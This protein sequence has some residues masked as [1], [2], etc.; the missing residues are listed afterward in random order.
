VDVVN[1]DS[2]KEANL[3]TQL[4]SEFGLMNLNFVYCMQ[5]YGVRPGDLLKHFTKLS[6]AEEPRL[7]LVKE[8]FEWCVGNEDPESF[9]L[10]AF[11]EVM[12]RCGSGR[13]CFGLMMRIWRW[14]SVRTFRISV[15]T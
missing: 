11:D 3:L 6:P 15:A 2:I 7:E 13:L 14:E 8:F 12:G 1:D 10:L 5:D 9:V 4:I